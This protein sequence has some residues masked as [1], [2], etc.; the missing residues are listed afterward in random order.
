MSDE[1]QRARALLAV[2]RGEQARQELARLLARAPESVEGH[3]LLARCHEAAD[4]YGAM[5]EC[6]DRAVAYAPDAEWPHRLRSIGLRK[7]SRVKDSVS[8][9]QRAVTLAPHIWQAHVNLVEALLAD[10]TVPALREAYRSVLQARELAPEEPE[11]HIAAGRFY[12]AISDPAAAKRCYQRT[13]A[14]DPSNGTARNNLA[15][16]ELRQGRPTRAGQRLQDVLAERPTEALYQRNAKATA[17]SWTHR[18]LE[19]GTLGWIIELVVV[20]LVSAFWVRVGTAVLILGSYLLIAALRYRRLSPALRRMVR[21]NRY[22]FPLAGIQ[23]LVVP[24]VALG[25]KSHSNAVQLLLAPLLLVAVGIGFGS[26]IQ[27]RNRIVLRTVRIWRRWRYRWTVLRA[28][29]RMAQT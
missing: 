4:R 19:F 5:L 13:L 28:V 2:G 7:L 9:A 16:V 11:V 10:G 17:V 20:Q 14:L 21:E 22:A 18:L 29:D 25:W 23:A 27:L 26:V 15:V 12:H 1:I 6:A 24:A 8:A 3:C